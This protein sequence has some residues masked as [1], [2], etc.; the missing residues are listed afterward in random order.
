MKRNRIYQAMGG[1]LGAA[2][3]LGMP[4]CTDD[5]YDIKTDGLPC[6]TNTIWQNI[7]ARQDLD[8][9]AMILKRVRV[10]TRED[11]PNKQKMTYSEYLS[12]PQTV[13]F[14]APV[15][16]SYNAKHYLDQLDAI[17]ELRKT[18]P[19]EAN[20]QEY[21][22]GQQFA[23]NHLARFN[24]ESNKAEQEIRL[25]NGK[26]CVYSPIDSL[27]NG[28]KMT[29]G[30]FPSTNGVL[31]LL[32][33]QSPFAYNIFD[34]MAANANIFEN[35]YGTLSDPA[36][37]KKEFDENLSIPGGLNEAGEMVYVD[38]IYRT[39]NELLNESGAQIKNED[40]LY[41]AVIP[42][43][44]AWQQAVE[45]VGKLFKYDKSYKYEYKNGNFTQTY[46]LDADSLSDY[47]LKKRL[48][49]SMYFTPSIFP[50]DFSRDDIDGIL[51]H[52]YNADSLISTNFVT[53]YNPTPGKKNPFFNCEP[54]KASNGIIFPLTSYDLDPSYSF[55][56]TS[57]IDMYSSYN[58]GYVK[59]SE[60]GLGTPIELTDGTWNDSLVD[61]SILGDQKQYRYFHTNKEMT[62]EIP[63]RYL[64]STS[65]RIK[66]IIVPN[67]A[68]P[69]NVWLDKDYNEVLQDTKFRA[70]LWSQGKRIETTGT[71]DKQ[72]I[73]VS[74]DSAKVY[75]IFESAEIPQC[76]VGL[77][78]SITD[79]YPILKII[80]H[81]GK[82]K[83][84][85]GVSGRKGIGI[86]KI[87]V[88][89]V[90]PKDE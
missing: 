45:K 88:E 39:T 43:D 11:D 44:A 29:E 14:W 65:Y 8:S 31:H 40:S 27:F 38:S 30:Y 52:V 66:A 7:E 83:Q 54:V 25:L 16:G 76:F 90:R 60:N 13:T 20:K 86:A 68:H 48:I 42:T 69:D 75:T 71:S 15:N 3:L 21:I 49:T 72:L 79:C 58:V 63:L 53:Y 1:F 59:N 35:V 62:I 22:L 37:D 57:R 67:R 23:Q 26:I 33:G 5:H 6:A 47:N 61:V 36:I 84:P 34:Y 74:D 78:N 70:E 9:L 18:S 51:N 85:A 10:Y 81:A 19:E 12:K 46:P 41:V 50:G 32:K 28:V 17:D 73:H 24:Y 80:C 87:I 4:S 77:P 56:G 2:M 82:Q 89:P 64:Y 55:V